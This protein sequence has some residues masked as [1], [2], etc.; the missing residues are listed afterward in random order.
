MKKR[1]AKPTKQEKKKALL[2]ELEIRL[3]K[4]VKGKLPSLSKAWDGDWPC[5][6]TLNEAVGAIAEE[7][8]EDYD[9]LWSRIEAIWEKEKK[10]ILFLPLASERFGG[11]Y[12]ELSAFSFPTGFTVYAYSDDSDYT[13][14]I[15]ALSEDGLDE[16]LALRLLECAF[17]HYIEDDECILEFDQPYTDLQTRSPLLE[18]LLGGESTQ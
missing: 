10:A 11:S 16:A 3:R 18:V 2:L 9:S 6:A 1:S 12:Q 7:S 5:T 15:L 17:G 14:L 4:L 8:G 13:G